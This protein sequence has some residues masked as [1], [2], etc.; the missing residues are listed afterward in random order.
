MYIVGLTGCVGMG[1][2][3]TASFLRQMGFPVFD[4]DASVHAMLMRGGRAVDAIAKAIPEVERDG[5][6]DRVALGK[7][8]FHDPALL[9]RL[10]A[11]LH[12]LV[13]YEER[14]FLRRAQWRGFNLAFMDIPLLFETSGDRRVNAVIC[15]TAPPAVQKER[16]MKRE[17][18]TEEKFHK[19]Q[20]LQWQDETK[21][22]LSDFVLCTGGGQ[23]DT[24]RRLKKIVRVL[25]WRAQSIARS[26]K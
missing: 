26:D 3:Q 12:P 1:K 10:E 8:A 11:I 7:L 17:G 6:I 4:A 16:V 24:L 14:R 23:A 25:K 19:V 15:V 22:A 18:M 21:R 20:S 5:A 13:E 2:T 9:K